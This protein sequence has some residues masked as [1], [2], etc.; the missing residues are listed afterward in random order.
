MEDPAAVRSNAKGLLLD[1]N[2]DDE[3]HMESTEMILI[4]TT[5][6]SNTDRTQSKIPFRQRVEG[7][8]KNYCGVAEWGNFITLVIMILGIILVEI[9]K[10]IHPKVYYQIFRIIRAI[11]VFGLSGGITNWLAVK[12]L[13]DKIP[14]LIGSGVIRNQFIEIRNCVKMVVLDTFFEPSSMME[15]LNGK[16]DDWLQQL[17]I[18]S[19]I[20]GV[21]KSQAADE[22][23]DKQL[24]LMMSRPEG[25]MLSFMGMSVN[26]LKP[27]ILPFIHG[28]G[29]TVSSVLSK[30]IQTSEFINPENI[31]K[32]VDELLSVKLEEMTATRVK[33]LVEHMIRKHLGWLVVWGNVFGAL[34]GIICE[35]SSVFK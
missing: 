28:L 17:D 21:L 11:G 15:Y 26:V 23:V 4:E 29:P 13:F 7:L 18:D 19:K 32:Q 9:F 33:A 6:E 5:N 34:I 31:R 1:A 16:Q 30:N 25:M 8:Y 3:I 24:S 20:D 12:M 27:T 10:H 2:N 35:V 14:G 22:I